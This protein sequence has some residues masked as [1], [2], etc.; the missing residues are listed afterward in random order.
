MLF[1]QKSIFL[2]FSIIT[3]LLVLVFITDSAAALAVTK[4]YEV[5]NE[6]N[7]EF[8]ILSNEGEGIGINSPP[9]L[10]DPSPGGEVLVFLQLLLERQ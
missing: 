2:L 1:N 5:G 7:I 9:D 6:N 3:L 4:N 10:R 8:E